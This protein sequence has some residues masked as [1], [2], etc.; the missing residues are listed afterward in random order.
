MLSVF[1]E[2]I[3]AELERLWRRLLRQP[4]ARHNYRSIPPTDDVEVDPLREEA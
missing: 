2:V 4:R 3:L 1:R